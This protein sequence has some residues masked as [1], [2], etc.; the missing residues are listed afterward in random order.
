MSTPIE[1]NSLKLFSLF[2]T[3]YKVQNLKII[4]DYTFEKFLKVVYLVSKSFLGA[5]SE[6]NHEYTFKKKSL[7]SFGYFKPFLRCIF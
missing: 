1:K 4:H 6:K 7:K 3:F 2:Q 5:N